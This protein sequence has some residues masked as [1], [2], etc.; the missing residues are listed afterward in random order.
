MKTLVS[1]VTA[2]VAITSHF[3]AKPCG[4]AGVKADRHCQSTIALKVVAK[5]QDGSKH[6][7]EGCKD[8]HGYLT[9]IPI[10]PER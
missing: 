9:A 6:L 4:C 8:T 10:G 3:R 2:N 5:D 7:L 1:V